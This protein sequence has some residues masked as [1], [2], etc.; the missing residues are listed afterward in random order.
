[1][2][3]QSKYYTGSVLWSAVPEDKSYIYFTIVTVDFVFMQN[4]T[5]NFFYTVVRSVIRI[6]TCN[7]DLFS[8]YTENELNHFYET[9]NQFS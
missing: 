5:V 9:T 3:V 1:M 4:I 2:K 6:K 7:A 8:M